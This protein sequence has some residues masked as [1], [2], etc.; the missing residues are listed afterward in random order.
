MRYS[1]EKGPNVL[2]NSGAEASV[3]HKSKRLQIAATGHVE[4]LGGEAAIGIHTPL[5]KKSVF[6]AG[7]VRMMFSL[8]KRIDD[9][10]RAKFGEDSSH[11][12]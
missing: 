11:S 7:R 1:L 12:L 8:S 2:T 5:W 9:H 10:V 4:Q 3:G 6:D